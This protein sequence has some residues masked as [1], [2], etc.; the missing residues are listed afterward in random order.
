MHFDCL[1]YELIASQVVDEDDA[2]E[3]D[4]LYEYIDQYHYDPAVEEPW[5]SWPSNPA[6]IYLSHVVQ[7]MAAASLPSL[8]AYKLEAADFCI[9]HEGTTSDR[10]AKL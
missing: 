6:S 5:L 9:T 10:Y 4:D 7:D 1:S 2:E 8:P 3:Q